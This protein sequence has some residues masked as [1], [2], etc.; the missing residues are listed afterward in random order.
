MARRLI[1]RLYVNRLR[2]QRRTTPVNLAVSSSVVVGP[3]TAEAKPNLTVTLNPGLHS[4][5]SPM[6][7]GAGP[8][9]NS[10]SVAPEAGQHNLVSNWSVA[11][12]ASNIA[13]P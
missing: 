13:H 5:L 2:N 6:S 8:L 12:S 3:N 4:H 9:A 7:H 11:V 1:K 10:A